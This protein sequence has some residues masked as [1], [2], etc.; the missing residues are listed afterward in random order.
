[1]TKTKHSNQNGNFPNVWQAV[2]FA[3]RRGVPNIT[4]LETIELKRLHFYLAARPNFWLWAITL[5]I[6]RPLQD[7]YNYI[8]KLNN[9]GRSKR[10]I[11]SRP[12]G[13]TGYIPRSRVYRGPRFFGRRKLRQA[14]GRLRNFDLQRS[15]AHILRNWKNLHPQARVKGFLTTVANREKTS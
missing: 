3:F 6:T 5:S 15:K 12:G 2:L 10:T 4:Y 7:H 8:D 9:Q 11:S 13:S 14:I 1:M